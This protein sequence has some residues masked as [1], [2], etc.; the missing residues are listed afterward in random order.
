MCGSPASLTFYYPEQGTIYVLFGFGYIYTPALLKK[1]LTLTPNKLIAYG[2]LQEK[3]EQQKQKQKQEL[4]SK[5]LYQ[6]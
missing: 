4:T 5:A 3:Y 2:Q 1:A 6:Y